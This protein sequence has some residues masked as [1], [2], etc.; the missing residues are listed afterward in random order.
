MAVLLGAMNDYYQVAEWSAMLRHQ[1]DLL[2]AMARDLRGGNYESLVKTVP[3]C[4]RLAVE[5]AQYMGNGILEKE[6]KM[7]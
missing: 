6:Q 5:M 4:H 1:R 3:V 7:G 2:D